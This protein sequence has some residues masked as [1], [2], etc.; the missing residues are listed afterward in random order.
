MNSQS[1]DYKRIAEGYAK[2]RPFLHGQ[3]IELLKKD[4]QITRNFSNGLDVG[5]GAGLSSKAL[6]LICDKVTGTDI[7]AEMIEAAK[8]F[9]INPCYTFLQSSAEEIRMPEN[10]FDVVTAAGVINWI[11]EKKFLANLRPLMKEKGILIIYD[12]WITDRMKES[13]AYTDWWHNSYLNRFPKPQRK[14]D[15]WTKETVAPYGF[16]LKNQKT[17]F[18]EYS[19]DKDAFIRFMMLQSNVNEQIDEKGKSEDEVRT[20]FENSLAP[21]FDAQKKILQFEGYYWNIHAR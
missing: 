2:D 10:T 5:C 14:E 3:V 18:L 11:D 13:A 6:K 21:I 17:Y 8:D 15:T 1:F 7:S 16:E 20:W 9:Y 19:F 12:F 4:L